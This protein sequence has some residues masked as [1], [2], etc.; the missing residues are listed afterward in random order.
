MNYR[1]LW[2]F[3][4][5][6][7][8]H[9]MTVRKPPKLIVFDLDNTLWTPEL[10][11][12]RRSLGDRQTPV[13][14]QVRS[15]EILHNMLL[16]SMLQHVKLFSG[17]SKVIERVRNGDYVDTT[18]FAVASRTKSVSW[19]FDLLEQFQLHEV[20]AYQEI[21]PSSKE[22][23]FENLSS[24]TGF[25]YSEMLFFD[26]ARD[27]KFGNCVPVANLGVLSVHCP[28]VSYMLHHIAILQE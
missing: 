4:I 28:R 15:D 2:C 6:G 3:G 18:Q 16:T 13:A 11:Q 12:L 23:H 10:Y 22:K 25:D 5:V 19:A 14:G 17:A 26:D 24:A 1:L 21:F 27:G 8:A 7:T 20:F 9:A